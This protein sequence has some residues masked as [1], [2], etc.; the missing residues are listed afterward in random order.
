M[1]HIWLNPQFQILIIGFSLVFITIVA[2]LADFLLQSQAGTGAKLYSGSISFNFPDAPVLTNV[3]N[4]I[5]DQVYSSSENSEKYDYLFTVMTDVLADCRNGI[6][7]NLT[8]STA[9]LVQCP[10]E[11]ISC[12]P[13]IDVYG[14]YAMHCN[15]SII[16][17]NCSETSSFFLS[18]VQQFDNTKMG[19]DWTST[20]QTF[21][22]ANSLCHNL[23][24]A[25]TVN[26]AQTKRTENNT[27]G[28]VDKTVVSQSWNRTDGYCSDSNPGCFAYVLGDILIYMLLPINNANQVYLDDVASFPLKTVLSNLLQRDL[29]IYNKTLK[30]NEFYNQTLKNLETYMM[31]TVERM[32]KVSLYNDGNFTAN[33]TCSNCA[34]IPIQ[35]VGIPALFI[36]IIISG[37]SMIM[38]VASVVLLIAGKTGPIKL[39]TEKVLNLDVDR[40]NVT[41]SRHTEFFAILT[42]C[43]PENANAK[44]TSSMLSKK[45]QTSSCLLLRKAKSI[46]SG[47][48]MSYKYNQIF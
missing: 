10:T 30:S 32:A 33:G 7:G 24:V 18:E 29:S 4:N 40:K 31:F 44:T 47:S 27:K 42:A 41:K 12:T 36:V 9:V 25:C 48:E 46:A 28:T 21:T 17:T 23:T 26:D 13:T 11:A 39:T 22:N 35:Y 37:V 38:A 6:C 16:E 14:D 5:M 15:N 2:T 19:F 20:I 45:S 1:K 43:D 3:P 34:I 8:N